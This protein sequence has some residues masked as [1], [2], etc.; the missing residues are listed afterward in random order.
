VT[1]FPSQNWQITGGYRFE[2][3]SDR[4]GG[5][6]HVVEVGLIRRF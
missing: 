4:E 3:R 1:Y 2:K 6:N 5:D